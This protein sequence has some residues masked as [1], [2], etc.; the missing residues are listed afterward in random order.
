MTST[1]ELSP[2]GS[3]YQ[4]L[5]LLPHHLVGISTADSLGPQVL[6]Q[7]STQDRQQWTTGEAPDHWG[8]AEPETPISASASFSERSTKP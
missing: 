6:T 2:L 5:A 7:C 8:A 4:V 1:L 3:S